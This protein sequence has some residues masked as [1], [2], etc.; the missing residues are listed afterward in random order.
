MER[1]RLKEQLGILEE[2]LELL[3]ATASKNRQPYTISAVTALQDSLQT[4]KTSFHEQAVL[5]SIPCKDFLQKIIGVLIREAA[6]QGSEI[7][8][9]SAASGKIS[10]E[11][12][13]VSMTAI[14]ACLR[15]SLRSY[16]GVGAA[17]RQKHHLFPTFSLN[18][19]IRATPEEV[20]FRMLDDG[21][22]FSGSFRAEFETEKQFERLRAHISRYGGWFRSKS[23]D[24]VGGLIEIKVPLPQIRFECYEI[25]VGDFRTLIPATYVAEIRQNWKPPILEGSN[26]V[27]GTL[28]ESEGL[29]VGEAEQQHPFG[30]KIAVADLQYWIGV[31]GVSAKVKARKVSAKD[32]VEA[33]SWIRNFGV[34]LE[35]SNAAILPLLEGEYL[36]SFY[37]QNREA[38][39]DL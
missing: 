30:L 28:S 35:E 37:A 13:E 15:A 38:H 16:K 5:K 8:V 29:L 18:V 27:Y 2:Q 36:V 9:V 14:V 23:L 32:F 7:S 26:A 31:D 39:E 24:P 1:Q 3:D 4:V 20:F 19:E 10:L 12:V 17:L 22:G 34:Y 21:Q 25:S 33:D 6:Q 11:M